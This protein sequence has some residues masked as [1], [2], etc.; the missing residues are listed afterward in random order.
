MWHNK[1]L[2][3][4]GVLSGLKVV[5]ASSSLAGPLGPTIFAEYGADVVWI[6]NA[7][8]PDYTRTLHNIQPESQE[9]AR[10]GH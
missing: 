3:E 2:P 6:E 5:H 4:F 10:N 8:A 1:A 7:Q 9:P